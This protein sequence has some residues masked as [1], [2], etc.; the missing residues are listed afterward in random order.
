[1]SPVPVKHGQQRIRLFA[2]WGDD[3]Q[4]DSVSQ[5][6][7]YRVQEFTANILINSRSPTHFIRS[8]TFSN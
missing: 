8:P 1:M 6:G 2:N 4:L 7:L 3:T 5:G